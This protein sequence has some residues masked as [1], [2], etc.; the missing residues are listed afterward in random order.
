MNYKKKRCLN[1]LRS[2]SSDTPPPRYLEIERHAS[3][4]LLRDR[5]VDHVLLQS[6]RREEIE[7]RGQTTQSPRP[8]SPLLRRPRLCLL[9][10]DNNNNNNDLLRASASAGA[11][12]RTPPTSS[13]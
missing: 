4:P 1:R 5:G 2:S 13:K 3:L 6:H 9:N 11:S 7:Q 10:L 8:L 12:P